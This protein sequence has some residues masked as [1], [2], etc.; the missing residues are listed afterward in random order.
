VVTLGGTTVRGIEKELDDFSVTMQDFS[1][2]VYSFDRGE[3]K[4]I[5]QD[6]ESLMP[7]YVGAFT[8]EEMSDVVKYLTT[9]GQPGG[10]P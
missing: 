2:R 10:H 6:S 5:Q 4:S 1:G 7:A 8:A 9:L 3:L